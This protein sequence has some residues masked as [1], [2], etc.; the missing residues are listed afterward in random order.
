MSVTPYV[1]VRPP[2]ASRS[3]HR[4]QHGRNARPLIS[5]AD[6]IGDPGGSNRR[7]TLREAVVTLA[8]ASRDEDPAV[9]LLSD[10]RAIFD[11]LAVG[12][13]GSDELIR[14]LIALDDA[15]WSEWRGP[16]NDQ[17]PRKLTTR[18]LALLLRPFGI[19]PRTIWLPATADGKATTAKGYHREW[20]AAAWARYS[21]A[22]EPVRP[23]GT[24]VVR[25]L[26]DR[27][28]NVDHHRWM[29]HA[30]RLVYQPLTGVGQFAKLPF[31]S[32]GRFEVGW[33]N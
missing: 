25:R 10:V 15:P 28:A 4:G 16:R 11:R 22:G 26:R 32:R 13:I 3:I 33:T 27:Y 8:G 1:P 19:R 20:F 5:I 6:A 2:P 21:D 31:A 7:P 30:G 17:Q 29:E 23:A 18:Q 14:E 9:T 24:S 12:R